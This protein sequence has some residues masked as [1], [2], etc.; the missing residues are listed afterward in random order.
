MFQN[1]LTSCLLT[2]MNMC[3]FHIPFRHCMYF[4]ILKLTVYLHIKKTKKQNTFPVY[5]MTL[6]QMFQNHKIDGFFPDSTEKQKQK[7]VHCMY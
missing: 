5:I 6:L 2:E 7:C 1:H 4:K 3:F